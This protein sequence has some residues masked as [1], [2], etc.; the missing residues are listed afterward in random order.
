V[1]G[2]D[3]GDIGDLMDRQFLRFARLAELFGNRGHALPF[4]GFIEGFATPD[5]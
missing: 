4:C 5:Y 3:L 2:T 1:V